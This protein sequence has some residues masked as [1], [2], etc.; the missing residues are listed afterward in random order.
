MITVDLIVKKEQSDSDD[1]SD[2]GDDDDGKNA[3]HCFCNSI[4][5]F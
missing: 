4:N 3:N 5:S 2:N 1:N